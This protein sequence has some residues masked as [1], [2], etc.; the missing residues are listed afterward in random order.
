EK[1]VRK[2]QTL[3]HW[4]RR[5][6]SELLVDIFIWCTDDNTTIPWNVS[7]VCRRWRTIALGTPKLW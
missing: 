2:H 5:S 4:T 7:Q 1:F 3:L 6:P